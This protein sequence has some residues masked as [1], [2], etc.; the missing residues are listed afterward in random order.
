MAWLEGMVHG[1][2]VQITART[3]LTG[4]AKPNAAA[5]LGASSEASG[6]A[7]SMAQSTLS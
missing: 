7:T 6:K 2:V 1:V 3:F 5:S 4:A